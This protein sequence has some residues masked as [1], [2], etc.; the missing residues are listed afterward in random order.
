MMSVGHH[1]LLL[2]AHT[3]RAC[4]A[5]LGVLRPVKVTFCRSLPGNVGEYT[6]TTDGAHQIRILDGRSPEDTTATLVHELTHAAQAE[7]PGGIEQQLRTLGRQAIEA[8]AKRTAA[9]YAG[10]TRLVRR[11]TAADRANHAWTGW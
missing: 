10:A 11:A 9:V 2:D 3:L 5:K 1:D 8:E 4:A 7:R 6:T